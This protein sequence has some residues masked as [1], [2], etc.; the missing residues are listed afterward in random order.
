MKHFK[1]D[2]GEVSYPCEIDGGFISNP[3]KLEQAV[4]AK[5]LCY[6]L[7]DEFIYFKYNM[8]NYSSREN[9]RINVL[10]GGKKNKSF[11]SALSI[12]QDLEGQNISRDVT[13][14]AIGGGV[15]GD[16]AG[17]IASCWYR[18]VDLIHVPTTLLSAVDSALG[19]KTAVNFRKTV[20]AVGTY[21]HPKK[22]IIDLELINELPERERASG[23]GE[24]IKY[25]MISSGKI[26]NVLKSAQNNRSSLEELIFLS[27]KDKERYVRGDITE[28]AKRLFLN[29]GHTIGH[30]IEFATIYEGSETL[31]H[32]EGVG[33]GMLA[34]FRISERLGYLREED[35]QMLKELLTRFG[36]PENFSAESIQ[37]SREELV[38]RV[39][40]L[41]LKDKKRT[42]NYLRLII[43]DGIGN[44]KIFE[45]NDMDLI[46]EGVCEVIV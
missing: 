10:K 41:T 43:L 6:M 39:V 38:E 27:L 19:G 14:V 11:A 44:P 40:S 5:S 24:I 31:R 1:V 16:I 4:D 22:L 37:V 13:I 32:G 36:L 23:F 18:G 17:F 2:L 26:L 21:K 29:F 28:S 12:F 20:N 30:A 34:I 9:W 25:G 15:V 45:T 35:V 46:C 33:L 3:E 42:S 7:V 8:A